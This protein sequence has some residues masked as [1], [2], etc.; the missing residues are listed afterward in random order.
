M[1]HAAFRIVL[2]CLLMLMV[3]ITAAQSVITGTVTE[4]GQPL[5]YATIT[6][7]NP[8]DSAVIA[9]AMTDAKGRYQLTVNTTLPK[10]LLRMR[11]MNY[12]TRFISI[13]NTSQLQNFA[14]HPKA[15]T[16]KEVIVRPPL[17]IRRGDTLSYNADAFA[18]KQD[19]TLADVLKKLPGMEV[20]ESGQ[21]SVQGEPI[22]KFYVEG[23]DLMGGRYGMVTNAL[24]NKDV[25]RIEVLSNH[26]PI[27][28][29]QGKIPSIQPAINIRLKKA[30]SY[31]GRAS[32]GLGLTPFLWTASA[33][34]MWFS[35]KQQVLL[36]YKTNNIGDNV[37]GEM[38]E[39]FFAA[40]F[41]GK[42]A[43]N[44]TGNRLSIAGPALPAIPLQRYLLNEVHSLSANALTGFGK[45]WELR[46]NVNY[47]NDH[48][49][50]SGG[51]YTEIRTLYADGTAAATIQYRRNSNVALQ[52][53]QFNTRATITKNVKQS[54]LKN[55]FAFR[56]DRNKHSG[57][58]YFDNEPVSQQLLSPGYSLQNSF[59]ILMP[60]N[61]TKTR[62]LNLR[63]F[64]NYVK[65]N[66][67]YFVQ[68]A[69]VLNFAEPQ[70]QKAFPMYQQLSSRNVEI[71]KEASLAFRFKKFTW[72]PSFTWVLQNNQLQS[73]LQAKDSSLRPIVLSGNWRN[74]MEFTKSIAAAAMSI[75]FDNEIFHFSLSL[76]FRQYHIAAGDKELQFNKTLNKSAFEPNM[77][78][79]Y[80]WHPFW[81]ITA[82]AGI[83]NTFSSVDN[84]YPGFIFSAL[85]FTAF[86]SEILQRRNQRAGGGISYKNDL[87]N[88]FGHIN[89]NYNNNNSNI[90][91]SRTIGA[92]GLQVTEAVRM[93]NSESS[94]NFN[95]QV[96]RYFTYWRTNLQFNYNYGVFR[97]NTLLN[98]VL[99]PVK[100]AI[101][102]F[103]A[104]LNINRFDWMSLEYDFSFSASK[105]Y[106]TGITTPTQ[107]YLHGMNA[108]FYPFKGNTIVGTWNNA[109][110][111]LN[112]QRFENK[113]FDLAWQYN[114]QKRK[115]DFEM[116]LLNIF[117][118]QTYR[119]VV[120]SAIETNSIYYTIRPRQLLFSVKFNL[121]R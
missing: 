107:L 19:R 16:L 41:E 58:M 47:V 82:N 29:L 32:A 94:G 45:D 100:T 62:N 21:I 49:T 106:A 91:L 4:E 67:D 102:S 98:N 12:A 86:R 115:M 37:P 121:R 101:Q 9:F 81:R 5:L 2:F 113:F 66:Q 104:K 11:L 90:I 8:A 46:L 26:Q 116:K 120:V 30:V 85:G 55:I 18:G 34:P 75:N 57:P 77:F 87:N 93:D 79:G 54:F 111:Q 28:M 42:T 60:V 3:G 110:Y 64:I 112:K 114:L 70:L 6:A 74:A 71:E 50:Q 108:F 36:T 15:V 38:K 78:L 56:T 25:S 14:T 20:S 92:N 13:D 1:S 48:Q 35:K 39:Q 68:P 97:T 22:N 51:N 76:P 118:T 117:N 88:I 73:A 99:L 40:G 109:V 119:Q 33:T 84:L 44:N 95:T 43:T 53:Q 105:R 83:S 72:V 31:T 69:A 63:S 61:K 17:I 65:E 52:L 59:S 103:S 89:Y 27:K 23:K 7:E 80:R 10:L 96:G 24:P